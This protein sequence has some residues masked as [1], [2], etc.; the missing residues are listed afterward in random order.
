[1]KIDGLVVAVAGA[2]ERIVA[3]AVIDRQ[4]GRLGVGAEV[5]YR[6]A[7]IIEA[8]GRIAGACRRRAVDL[9]R[10][11]DIGQLRRDDV[12]IGAAVVIILPEIRHEGV[13]PGI[14][15]VDRIVRIAGA[16]VV[17]ALV[18]EAEGVTDFVEVG[19]VA[20][21]VDAGLAVVC[22]AVLGDPVRADIDV[23]GRNDARAVVAVVLVGSHRAGIRERDVCRT[24]GLDEGQVGDFVPSI[25]GGLREEFLVRIQPVDVVGDGGDAPV[26]GDRACVLPI[27][28]QQPI[29]QIRGR[30][31]RLSAGP[32]A[33]RA[34]G[35]SVLNLRK[36]IISRRSY[37][38]AT[39]TL[40]EIRELTQETGLRVILRDHRNRLAH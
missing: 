19:L 30:A 20:V 27:A 18:A 9:L 5:E 3:A 16:A 22:A 29:G 36:Q 25:E 17:R 21:T 15:G 10:R 13:L 7:G 11:I 12:A 6:A 4:R 28:G 14:V 32:C 31:D 39:A 40:A 34:R 37:F 38:A 26:M 8:V 1:M 33:R 24:A 35:I 2:I 23:R